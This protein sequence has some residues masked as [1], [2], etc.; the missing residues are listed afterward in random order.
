[1]P[2]K[3]TMKSREW[4]YGKY[5]TE[6]L[7]MTEVAKIL[8]C[9]PSTVHKWIVKYKIPARTRSEA[10]KGIYKGIR[11]SPAT[12]FK[13]GQHMGVNAW[14]WKGGR[15]RIHGGYIGILIPEHPRAIKSGYVLEHRLVMEKH[16][17]RYLESHEIVHH[18]NG[19]KD[20]NRIE[21]LE[22]MAGQ[23]FHS[24]TYRKAYEDGYK[25]GFKDG[26]YSWREK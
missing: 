21:N 16:I 23:K 18:I 26:T 20:D 13:K 15:N 5:I 3:K 9:Y 22:L 10:N 2:G 6:K 19:I 8:N 24:L 17:G 4:L 25:Q 14:N 1:M 12:E 11:R 7:S